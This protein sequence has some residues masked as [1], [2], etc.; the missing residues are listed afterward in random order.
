MAMWLSV[1]GEGVDVDVG[2]GTGDVEVCVNVGKSEV[3]ITM[4]LVVVMILPVAVRAV[5]AVK[6]VTSKLLMPLGRQLL[7]PADVIVTN[8][9]LGHSGRYAYLQAE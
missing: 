4:V 3:G 5:T 7:F 1:L 6:V 2:G 9:T 8:R